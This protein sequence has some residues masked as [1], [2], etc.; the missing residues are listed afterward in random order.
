MDTSSPHNF[1]RSL[2]LPL[3]E[4][5]NALPQRGKIVDLGCGEGVIAEF[6]ARKN[7]RRVIGVDLDEKRLK[8]SGQKNLRFQVG[9]IRKFKLD[10][11]D[12]VIISDVLHHV[13]FQDQKS[14]LKNITSSLKKGG[15]LVIKEIDTGEFIRSKLSRFWDLVFYPGDKI[16]FN[17]AISL[18]KLLESY[19]FTVSIKRPTRLFPGSTTLFVCKK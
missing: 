13:N 6:L 12:G 2:M 4:I 10:K 11:I 7:S 18:K 15:V 9:D 17:D 19:G 3:K 1:L 5:D 16:Y 14:I 8:E